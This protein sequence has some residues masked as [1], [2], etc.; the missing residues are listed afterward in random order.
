MSAK[1]IQ[2]R[3]SAID[4]LNSKRDFNL[5][6]AILE[7]SGFRPGVLMKLKRQGING[8]EATKRLTHLMRELVQAWAS[9]A[10]GGRSSSKK[11]EMKPVG[12][13]PTEVS[14]TQSAD[15]N[16]RLSLYRATIEL[17]Q[18]KEFPTTVAELLRKY[19]TIYNQRDKQHKQMAELPE[20]NDAETV[21]IRKE[22][23]DSIAEC[24]EELERLYPLYE[25][26]MNDAV[27]PESDQIDRIQETDSSTDLPTDESLHVADAVSK[28]ELQKQRKSV[29]T[30]LLRARNMLEFQQETKA[31]KPNRM[32]ESPKR[33]K[34]ETKVSNL[35]AELEKLEYQIA[36]LG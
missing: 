4:W 3:Q 10:D 34:Y 5:G 8:P 26:Y 35:V 21:S 13:A 22:L 33:L 25:Q 29:A 31:D 9:E 1:Y 18:G 27:L 15:N 23:S 36:A 11:D 6:I 19:A 24:T 14:S 2:F 32:P 17:E 30:K 28:T 7:Q 20:D 16:R 12:D